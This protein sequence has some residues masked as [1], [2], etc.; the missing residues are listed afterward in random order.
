MIGSHRGEGE[1]CDRVTDVVD[2]VYFLS[3]FLLFFFTRYFPGR[4]FAIGFEV[5]GEGACRPPLISL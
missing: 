4:R 1:G 5:A 3:H 2:E